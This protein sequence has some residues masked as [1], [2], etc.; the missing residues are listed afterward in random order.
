M[1][2]E[3]VKQ[4]NHYGSKSGQIT[5]IE[6]ILDFDL[7]FCLGN[8]FK[9]ISRAGKKPDE[10]RL[11]DLNKAMEYL[12]FEIDSMKKERKLIGSNMPQGF[13]T[14]Q[15]DLNGLAAYTNNF[16]RS[17]QN[18]S[19][20]YHVVSDQLVDELAKFDVENH[21]QNTVAE[22]TDLLCQARLLIAQSPRGGE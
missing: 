12:Q 17:P 14:P 18:V 11:T 15:S 5:A 21:D 1:T 16:F 13:T 9:Y 20:V 7:N 10:D 2:Y 3:K 6:V 4:P 8:V 19:A 22:I